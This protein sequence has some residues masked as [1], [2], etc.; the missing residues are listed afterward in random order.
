MFYN[1]LSI[2]IHVLQYTTCIGVYVKHVIERAGSSQLII[3]YQL[4]SVVAS[5]PCLLQNSLAKRPSR[6]RLSC[7]NPQASGSLLHSLTSSA[8]SC[9][10]PPF[11]SQV[12][13]TN[14]HIAPQ[15]PSKHLLLKNLTRDK[16]VLFFS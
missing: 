12:L 14:E 11:L 9:F 1:T 7:L 2:T 8:H 10:P 6:K 4:R 5:H 15:T 3:L 16:Y 13:I